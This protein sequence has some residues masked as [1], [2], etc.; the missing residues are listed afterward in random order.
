MNI[1]VDIN[2]PITEKEILKCVKLSKRNKSVGDDAISKEYI[3][4]TVDVMMSLYIALFNTI[5]DTG[6][7]PS[8]WLVGNIVPIYKNKGDTKDPKNYRSIT[9]LSCLGKLFTSILNNRL[10]E[11][12]DAAQ[13]ILNNQVGF[14]KN[15]S[16]IDHIFTLHS[17]TDLFKNY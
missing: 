16:T 4:S 15:Y 8:C 10:N 17:L 14:R 6:I 11:Y 13:L 1:N 9:I 12:A 3:L 7:M 2:V 5:F